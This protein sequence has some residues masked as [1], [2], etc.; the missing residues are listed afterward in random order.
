MVNTRIG[1]PLCALALAA[2]PPAH[3][4]AQDLAI[5]IGDARI[6]A[7]E[8]G[9][10]DLYVR[11]K[12]DIASILLTESTKDPAMKADNFAYRASEYNEVNGSEKRM[13]NGKALPP[14]S[15]LYS[16]ISSTPRADAAF[17]RAFQILVPP[18]LV[19]GYPWSRSGT[20]AVGKGTF[21]NIRAFSKPYAD[22]SGSFRDNPYQIAISTGPLP[23]P[24]APP[25]KPKPATMVAPSEE[26]RAAPPPPP[27]DRTSSKLGAAI[28][29]VPGQSLDLVVCLD[30]T[31]S[32]VPYLDDIK[33]N[34]GPHPPRAS[35]GLFAL[36]R[37]TRALQGLLA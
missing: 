25:E 36:P 3:L 29:S 15:N 34:L 19:Y 17:G 22:Y 37:R 26:Q 32:M 2:A 21:I 8:D 35:L 30:T 6:E 27:D 31:A 5:G 20:V 12:P 10:Y 13:L 18:V 28:E 23:P 7:R 11:A 24:S 9:G 14:A 4:G 1:V 16:L 33:K